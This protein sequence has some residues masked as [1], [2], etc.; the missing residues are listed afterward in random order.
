MLRNALHIASSAALWVVFV[1]YWRIVLRQPMNPDTRTA[2]VILTALA[3]LG[4]VYITAWIYHN[5]RIF[6][7][8]DRRRK[9]R[10]VA[11]TAER[12]YLGR[13]LV[14]ER[15]ETLERSNYIEVEMKD[16][17]VGGRWVERKIFK[18]REQNGVKF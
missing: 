16:G 15:R 5:L 17:F 1:Y 3:L 8:S 11:W 14:F 9:R 7:T 6:R 13:I 10:N 18:P 2:L 4:I 12:D